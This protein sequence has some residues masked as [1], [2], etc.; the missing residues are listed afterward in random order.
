MEF[1]EITKAQYVGDHKIHLWF[2]NNVE[3]VVD[4]SDKLKG[5]AFEPLRDLTFFKNFHITYNTIEWANG[6]DFAPEY[7]LTC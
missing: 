4:V 6:A 2:N 3:R 7:L 1:L 5:A